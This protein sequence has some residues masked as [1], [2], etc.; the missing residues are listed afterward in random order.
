MLNI[1]RIAVDYTG[2]FPELC[3]RLME[4]AGF[5]PF[6]A[7]ERWP[8]GMPLVCGLDRLSVGKFRSSSGTPGPLIAVITVKD[9]EF[10]DVVEAAGSA[11]AYC[12]V[13]DAAPVL[14]ATVLAALKRW[15]IEKRMHESESRFRFI[16]EN[17][18]DVIWTWNI[19]AN[20]FDYISPSISLLRGLSVEEALAEKLE[21]SLAPA[22]AAKARA[23][24]AER[25]EQYLVSGKL[26]P[27]T[28]LYEQRHKDGSLRTV[29]ITT[30]VLLDAQGLPEE[31]LGVSRDATARVVADK[32]LKAA[33]QERDILLSELGHRIKN[34]L[35]LTSS[36]LS[37]AKSKVHDPADG[38][39]FE[40][41][42]SRVH[43]MA[44]LYERLLKSK[45]Q[46]SIDFKAYLKELC[47][48]LMQA[49]TPRSASGGAAEDGAAIDLDLDDVSMDSSRAV[50]L[51]LAVNEAL[52]NSFK[53][54]LRP[55]TVLR[56]RV[57]ARFEDERLCLSIADNGPGLPAGFSIEQSEGLGFQLIRALALQLKGSLSLR[58]QLKEEEGDEGLLLELCIPR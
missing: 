39:L 40:E 31:V 58:N 3:A 1:S 52:T 25:M 32:L 14:R 56:I 15:D 18:G 35:S 48:G 41:S 55:D 2:P 7:D 42:Q 26:V 34:T 44:L 19:K 37:L 49:Y 51:G 53:Y 27:L 33:L 46:G 4:E 30:T 24:M 17:V 21:D 43:A 28:D 29:E 13:E 38:E 5:T 9:L 36:L 54:A 16:A 20:R 10:S 11:H 50:S 6:K 57:R 12:I 8:V 45:A 23:Q 22:A 47:A